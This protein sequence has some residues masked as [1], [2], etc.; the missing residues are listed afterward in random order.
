VYVS[1]IRK[2][3]QELGWSPKT[4]VREGV[5]KL[6]HWVAENRALFA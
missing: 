1:D 6:F 4:S 5:T 3:A 2:A